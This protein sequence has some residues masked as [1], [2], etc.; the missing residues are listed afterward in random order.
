MRDAGALQRQLDFQRDH[1]HGGTAGIG[2]R[3]RDLDRGRRRTATSRST[4]RS[5]M[6]STGISGSTTCAAASQA[7]RAQVGIGCGASPRRPR[8]RALH[9]LQL[10]EEMAENARCAG[11]LRPPCC[12][13][14][15]L[16]R[17]SVASCDDVGDR[18]Q[19]WR[20]QRRRIDRDAGIDQP[21]LA[22]VDVEHFAGEAPRD[23]RS[24][25]ARGGGS[26]RCRRRG[27]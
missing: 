18:L 13:Q 5:A 15:F 20:A 12:I 3:D 11:R 27:G 9:R 4:P 16:G 10:A 23:R 19:P 25:P 17:P 26:P 1:V 14:S 7:R 21:A 8:K 2:R 24:R 6:V 22:V